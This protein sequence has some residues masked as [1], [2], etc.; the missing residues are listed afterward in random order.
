MCFNMIWSIIKK[1][2][3]IQN[4]EKNYWVGEILMGWSEYIKQ[5][6]HIYRSLVGTHF[7]DFKESGDTA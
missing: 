1:K 2:M 4:A 3:K 6:F 5:I 7:N